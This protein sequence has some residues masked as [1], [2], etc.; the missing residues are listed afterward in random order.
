MASVARVNGSKTNVGVLYNTDCNLYLITVK[1]ANATV[2]DLQAEDSAGANAVVDGVVEQI[3]KE[4][5]PLAYFTPANNSGTI[6]VVMPLAIDS[7][8]E[9]QT[10]IRRIG[11]VSGGTTTSVG[12]NNVDI[13]GTTVAAAQ[14]FIIS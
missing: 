10:R 7:A 12:P 8:S 4:I 1:Q 13:S 14:Q 5:S 9:L 11:L 2:V 3:V 6:N